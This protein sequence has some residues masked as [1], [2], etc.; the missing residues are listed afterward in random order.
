MVHRNENPLENAQDERRVAFVMPGGGSLGAVQVG[1]LGALHAH[2]IIADLVVGTSVGGFNAAFIAADPINGHIAL[3]DV[4]VALQR[5]DLFALAPKGMALG[6]VGRRDA[7]FGNEK[8]LSFLHRHAPLVRLEHAKIP[9]AITATDFETGHPVALTHGPAVSA[10]LA[11]GA[12]PGIFP[13]VQRDSRLLVDGGVSAAWPVELALDMGATDVYVL[14]TASV[15][16]MQRRRGALAMFERGID[17]IT[18]RAVALERR[19]VFASHPGRIHEIPAPH[20]RTSILDLSTTRD[21]IDAAK[22]STSQWL[23][24]HQSLTS[25]PGISNELENTT[26]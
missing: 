12:I 26:A 21:L 11:T 9:I 19:A 17:I 6:L 20:S 4:W 24:E 14:E 22:A 16:T 25:S 10:L 18:D 15:Q 3:H 1:M 8:L 5:R 13:A 2:G 7:I 23:R